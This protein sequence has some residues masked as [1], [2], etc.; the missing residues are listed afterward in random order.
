[1]TKKQ[2]TYDVHPIG[3]IRKQAGKAEIEILEKY[4]D[5]LMGLDDFSHI[6]VCYWLHKNDT[7]EERNILRVHPKRHKENPL[8]GVFA[9][10]SSVRP[11]LLAI[12]MCR[13]LSIDGTVIQIDDID[14][15]DQTP[16]IDI[17]P[18]IPRSHSITKDVKT[19]QWIEPK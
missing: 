10:C 1:M 13:I 6:I 8:T 5:A 17:K 9:T 19:P 15:F 11:N 2:K 7:A 4:K 3:V 12:S 18:Y 16:V 14:A